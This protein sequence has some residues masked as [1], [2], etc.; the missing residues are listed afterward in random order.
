MKNGI[1]RLL[2]YG[3]F[4][5]WILALF[6]GGLSSESAWGIKQS[7]AILCPEDTTPGHTTYQQTVTDSDGD[8]STDTVWILQCKA[9]NGTVVKEIPG[10]MWPWMGIF[11]GAAVV[12]TAPFLL[13]GVIMVLISWN[14]NRKQSLQAVRPK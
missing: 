13:A 8:R 7:G 2:I 1:A 10:Y 14:K 11:V 6:V 5:L 3:S 9:A 12:L 4:G